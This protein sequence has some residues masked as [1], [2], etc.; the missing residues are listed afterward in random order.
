M[1]RW[2]DGLASR[3]R[4]TLLVHGEQGALEAMRQRLEERGWPAYVPRH[5]EKVA[6]S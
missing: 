5:L 6:L 3:P 2:M 4:R 1:L